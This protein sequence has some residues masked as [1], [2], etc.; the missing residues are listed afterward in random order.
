MSISLI[1]ASAVE[2][3]TLADLKLQCGLSPVEDADRVKELAT[4]TLLRRYIRGARQLCENYTRRV[5]IT[6]TWLLQLDNWP[7]NKM[8]YNR[9]GY[10]QILLPKPP[11]QKI[12]FFT[13]VDVA[14]NLQNI[15]T[16]SMPGGQDQ[17]GSTDPNNFTAPV[18][19][20]Q[21]DSGSE[22]QS[23]RLTPPWA[24]PWPPIR[25]IPNNVA[26]QF[27][28]GYGGTGAAVPELIL[29]AILLAGQF[30]YDGNPLTSTLPPIVT[31]MLDPYVNRVS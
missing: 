4:A 5:F 14:G 20:C 22:T 12:Q 24:Q 13:Y 25:M 7:H 30:L 23:A 26:V 21:I 28:C 19:T 31:Q 16:P 8:E 1:A 27:V 6:Q 29:D 15:V 3:V 10:P 18:Y 9:H 17:P 11:F 2:P